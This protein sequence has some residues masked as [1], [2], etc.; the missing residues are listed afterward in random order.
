MH[1]GQ[2]I[3]AA[4]N[5]RHA[6]RK[7]K[8]TYVDR[9]LH[10]LCIYVCVSVLS[11][12]LCVWGRNTAKRASDT[13]P[14]RQYIVDITNSCRRVCQTAGQ[15][16]IIPFSPPHITPLSHTEDGMARVQVCT[17]R[18]PTHRRPPSGR[19]LMECP[20][21]CPIDRQ[22]RKTDVHTRTENKQGGE[23]NT[24]P[25]THRFCLTDA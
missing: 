17:G 23:Q 8:P 1:P 5:E 12:C 24:H 22:Q 13:S 7:E 15:I 3:T 2:L 19:Q 9:Q 18:P 4:N 14:C 20:R 6:E 11:V 25:P 10:A 16:Q 21:V